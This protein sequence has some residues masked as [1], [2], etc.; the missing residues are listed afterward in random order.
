MALSGQEGRRAGGGGGAGW[1]PGAT[2]RPTPA[3]AGPGATFRSRD[4]ACGP[5]SQHTS[6]AK[7]GPRPDPLVSGVGNKIPPLGER[8]A[9]TSITHSGHWVIEPQGDAEAVDGKRLDRWPPPHM[10]C[11]SHP[12]PA[13][14]ALRAATMARTAAST[15]RRPLRRIG[16][17]P[18]H[19]LPTLTATLRRL[20]GIQR[21]ERWRHLRRH[22]PLR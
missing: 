13:P 3:A 22:C 15:H 5:C 20:R 17:P 7:V 19:S 1:G 11:R 9:P 4:P 16:P 2:P 12:C 6:G 10:L 14:M 18:I 8:P 21:L